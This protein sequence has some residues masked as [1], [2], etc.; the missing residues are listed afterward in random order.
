MSADQSADAREVLRLREVIRVAIEG[1]ESE[2]EIRPSYVRNFLAQKV[3]DTQQPVGK[4]K[5]PYDDP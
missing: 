1:L 2:G 5:F 3:E 4:I